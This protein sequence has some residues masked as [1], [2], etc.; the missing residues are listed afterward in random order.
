MQL[1]YVARMTKHG[2]VCGS[3]SILNPTLVTAKLF[4]SG[5]NPWIKLDHPA[6]TPFK[7][8]LLSGYLPGISVLYQ[9][10]AWLPP[11]VRYAGNARRPPAKLRR[12]IRSPR[13]LSRDRSTQFPSMLLFS[14]DYPHLLNL[15]YASNFSSSSH[16]KGKSIITND[17]IY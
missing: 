6:S 1:K 11:R 2:V 5:I 15:N 14:L 12:D 4:C 17:H 13:E 8:N 3:C 16:K 10:V 9:P 7:Q